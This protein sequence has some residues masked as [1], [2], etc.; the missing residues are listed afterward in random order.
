MKF[1]KIIFTIICTY[2]ALTVNPLQAQMSPDK[3]P[4]PKV[5]AE[6]EMESLKKELTLT[7]EQVKKI[8]PINLKYAEKRKEMAEEAMNAGDWAGMGAK[9]E[10]LSQE[11]SAELK[12][13]LTDAQYVDYQKYVKKMRAKYS[14]RQ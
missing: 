6:K 12:P 1:I 10:T 9:M 3:M 14:R 11:K 7:E 2:F 13:I 5:I 4:E 8:A